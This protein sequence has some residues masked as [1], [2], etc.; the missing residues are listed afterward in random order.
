[1]NHAAWVLGHLAYVFDS[2]IAV[3]GQQPSMSRKWKDLFNLASKPHG[4]RSKYP[5]KAALWEAYEQ[6]YQRIVDVVKAASDEQLA[7]ESPIRGIRRRRRRWGWRW[8]TSSPRTK[9]FTWVN[10]R[11]GGAAGNAAGAGG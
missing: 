5:S 11:P 8:C 4:D 2:M 10:Y 1:M 6:A 9:A 7:G 3:W